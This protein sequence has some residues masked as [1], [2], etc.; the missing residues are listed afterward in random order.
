MLRMAEENGFESRGKLPECPF[1]GGRR[2]EYTEDGAAAA[3]HQRFQG[4]G[5]LQQGTGP[6]YFR[7][8]GFGNRLQDIADTGA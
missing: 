7:T 4:T 1:R 8:E 6:A 2:P 3:C 5:F